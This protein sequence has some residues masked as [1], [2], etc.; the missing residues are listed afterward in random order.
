ME[1]KEIYDEFKDRISNP[2]TGSF[3]ISWIILN[4]QIPVGLIFYKQSELLLDT[5]RSFI[6]LIAD[7]Y[8]VENMLIFPFLFALIYTFLVPLLTTEIKVYLAKNL[9][10][11][12]TRIL[13][14]NETTPISPVRYMKLK[15]QLA[16]EKDNYRA[17]LT[18]ENQVMQQNND[19]EK[20]IEASELKLLDVE[21]GHKEV[22]RTLNVRLEGLK[23]TVETLEKDKIAQQSKIH[24]S[25][26]Q[27]QKTQLLLIKAQE[28]LDVSV[29]QLKTQDRTILEQV[30]R[31]KRLEDIIK[32]NDSALMGGLRPPS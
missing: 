6:A 1:I 23:E 3:V 16:D 5:H 13:L 29:G 12:D 32:N 21:A 7:T 8:N 28:D 26:D 20:Q 17:L 9:A 18:S 24:S 4:Y 22:I 11:R 30:N 2:F 15:K 10:K 31:I 27:S 14:I 25:E 19:L